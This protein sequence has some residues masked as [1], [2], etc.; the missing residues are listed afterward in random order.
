MVKRQL[1]VVN[2]VA[3]DLVSHVFDGD[4][5]AGGHVGVADPAGGVRGQGFLRFKT[6]VL[7]EVQGNIGGGELMPMS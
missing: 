6:G 5:L 2:A 4:A 1:A 7:S 3:A